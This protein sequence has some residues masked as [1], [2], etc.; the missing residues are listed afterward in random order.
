MDRFENQCVHFTGKNYTAW[1]FQF[2]TY[3]RGKDLW[4]HITDS[5]PKTS[6]ETTAA[7]DAVKDKSGASAL[8]WAVQDAQIRSW[9]L[10]TMKPHILLHLRPYQTAKEMWEYLR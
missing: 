10:G 7:T 3:L 5:N 2:E 9:I 6:S 4:N 1:E 8:S